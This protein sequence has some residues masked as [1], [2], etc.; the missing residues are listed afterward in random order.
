MDLLQQLH[1][2]GADGVEVGVNL[3]QVA[4][5]LVLVEMAIEGDLVANDA[6]LV[7]L[8]VALGGV[9]PRTRNVGED[10]LF[11]IGFVE[12]VDGLAGVEGDVLEVAQFA[13]GHVFDDLSAHRETAVNRVGLSGF[14][15]FLDDLRRLGIFPRYRSGNLFLLRGVEFDA[16]GLEAAS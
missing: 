7:V 8:G 6:D 10:F 15:D 5:R 2:F 16:G 1:D 12:R 4:G 14:M 3:G 13:V 11:E 9:D